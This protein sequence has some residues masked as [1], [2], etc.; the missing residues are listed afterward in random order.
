LQQKSSSGSRPR[1]P[2]ASGGIQVNFCKNP[3]C[4]NFGVVAAASTGKGASRKKDGYAVRAAGKG[5]PVLHCHACGEYPPVKSNV[6]IREELERLS[7]YLERRIAPSCP[8]VA[9]DSHGVGVRADSNAYQA[10]GRTTS[11]GQRYRCKACGRTFTVR[12]A[13]AGQRTPHKNKIVFSLLMNKAPFRR[14]G[15]VADINPKTL[16]DK[17]DF[18]H[19]QSLAFAAHRE[20]RLQEGLSIPRLYIGVDRQDYMVNWTRREDK[21]NVRLTAV[22]SADNVTG[23]VFGMHLNFDPDLKAS[24]IETESKACGDLELPHPFRR[25]ARLWLEADYQAAVQNHRP[26]PIPVTRQSLSAQITA[27]YDE[28]K[29]R[30][31]IEDCEVADRT[32]QL[33]DAG[34]QIHAEYTLYGHFFLLRR[35]LSGVEKIRFFLDQDAGMRAACLGAFQPAFRDRRCDAFYVHI[36]K[37]MTVDERKRA[38]ADSRKAF[39]ALQEERPDL[40]Q[41]ELRLLLI[42]ERLHAMAAIGQWKDRWLTHPF[43]SMNESEKAVCYLTDYGDYDED[44]LAWLYNKASLRAID[45]FF[46]LVRRRLSLLERPLA[47]MSNARRLWYGYSAYNPR[48]I[49][50]VLDIF[51]VFY[52]Y[53]L[54]GQDKKTPAMRL[55]L[56]KGHVSLEDIIYYT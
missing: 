27:R 17:I 24:R 55:G 34:M 49:M 23:Y 3:G 26:T 20:R 53:V 51:R 54:I 30:E 21:R 52:N 6:A 42:K 22:G 46:M 14:I 19:R 48:S 44:H 4:P 2:L 33:P 37:D 47:T 36:N 40:D 7:S 10:F 35:L 29:V 31:D 25:H 38:L 12:K 56:A 5:L 16:Y 28:A 11:G 45:V 13:T 32:T 50:K 43:P 18:L 1:I 15:E 41:Q 39:R 9:C 8:N